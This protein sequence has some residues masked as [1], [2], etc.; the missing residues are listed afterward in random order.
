LCEYTTG[1]ADLDP[2]LQGSGQVAHGNRRL[3]R[4]REPLRESDSL[5]V[6]QAE[7]QHARDEVLVALGR[8]LRR[9]EGE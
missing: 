8:V 2:D 7:R 5:P 4:L 6:L 1:S 3:V 9:L